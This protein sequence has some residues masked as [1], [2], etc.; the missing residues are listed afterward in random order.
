VATAEKHRL[1]FWQRTLSDGLKATWG[2][3]HFHTPK[4]VYALTRRS[5]QVT[6]PLLCGY[7]TATYFY[8]SVTVV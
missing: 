2:P 5:Q 4:A 7:A 8:A 3:Q 1:S 6:P